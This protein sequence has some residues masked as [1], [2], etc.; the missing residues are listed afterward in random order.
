MWTTPQRKLHSLSGNIAATH[1]LFNP[2][3]RR[4]RKALRLLEP[5]RDPV[6]S[7][8]NL[9]RQKGRDKRRSGD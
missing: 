9:G 1:W 8:T 5:I 6:P 3:L 4:R 2:D 7:G